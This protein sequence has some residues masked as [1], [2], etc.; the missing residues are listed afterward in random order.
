ML[1]PAPTTQYLFKHI[2]LGKQRIKPDMV[3]HPKSIHTCRGGGGPEGT[4]HRAARNKCGKITTRKQRK[5]AGA[6]WGNQGVFMEN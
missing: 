6:G 4:P 3:R 5:D 1:S 2:Y